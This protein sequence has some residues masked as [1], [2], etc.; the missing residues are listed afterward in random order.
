MML[1]KGEERHGGFGG[2]RG[3]YLNTWRWRGGAAN[4][5]SRAVEV[6]RLGVEGPSERVRVGS[7]GARGG[8]PRARAWVGAMG[9]PREDLERVVRS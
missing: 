2:G 3:G 7:V 5:A 1:G 4:G 9:S 6:Q 8:G